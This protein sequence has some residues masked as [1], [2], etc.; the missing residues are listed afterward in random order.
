[1]AAFNFIL[2]LFNTLEVLDSL[3]AKFGSRIFV[4]DQQGPRV[5]LQSGKCPLLEA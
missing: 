5:H 1:M 3:N 4:Y 2:N